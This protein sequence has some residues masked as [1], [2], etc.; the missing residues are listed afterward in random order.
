MT[1]LTAMAIA[2]GYTEVSTFRNRGQTPR[3]L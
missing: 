2:A 3:P 1:D